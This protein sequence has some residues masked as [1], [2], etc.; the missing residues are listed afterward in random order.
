MKPDKQNGYPIRDRVL[1]LLTDSEA[2][3]VRLAEASPKLEVGDEFLN[4]DALEKG[5]RYSPGSDTPP[6]RLVP[7]KAVHQDAWNKMVKALA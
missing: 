1:A 7:R 6:G 5:V 3:Q 2:E 4:L